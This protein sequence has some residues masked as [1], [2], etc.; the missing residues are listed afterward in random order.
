MRCSFFDESRNL[1]WMGD[2]D[3]VAGARDLDFVAVGPRG[4]P[5]FEIGIDGSVASGVG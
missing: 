5:P 1:L 3:C 4:I 2:L